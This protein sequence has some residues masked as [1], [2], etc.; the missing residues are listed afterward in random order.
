[1]AYSGF[2]FPANIGLATQLQSIVRLNGGIPATIGILNG[3]VQIG[4]EKDELV[5]LAS[6]AGKPETRKVSTRDL[7]HICGLVR[8]QHISIFEDL[9]LNT[10]RRAYVGRS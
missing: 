3:R 9:V 1:M 6:S 2:P 7:P 5:E 10:T 4:F 8:K